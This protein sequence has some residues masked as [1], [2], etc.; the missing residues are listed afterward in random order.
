MDAHGIVEFH[1]MRRISTRAMAHVA[2]RPPEKTP[3]ELACGIPVHVTFRNDDDDAEDTDFIDDVID[4]LR[5]NLLRRTFP[6]TTASER[7]DAYLTSFASDL[8]YA[9][10]C[11]SGMETKA[12]ARRRA[13][14]RATRD[15][16]DG[17]RGTTSEATSA[18]EREMFRRFARRCRETLARRLVERCYGRGESGERDKFW[19]AFAKRRF[20]NRPPPSVG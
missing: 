15:E 18:G 12:S 19:M 17:G 6:L 20:L 9:F 5:V 14:E 4:N 1:R 3:R 13:A 8:L 11:D 10:A 2:T 16:F 7:L